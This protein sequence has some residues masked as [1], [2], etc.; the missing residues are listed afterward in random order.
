[1]DEGRPWTVAAGAHG[2][3]AARLGLLCPLKLA[4]R[5]LARASNG[6]GRFSATVRQSTHEA[7][8]LVRGRG[9]EHAGVVAAEPGGSVEFIE[10]AFNWLCL[11]EQSDVDAVTH[12]QVAGI[13]WV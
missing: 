9:A 10:C 1:M 4:I 11:V 13:I 2:L 7:A 3:A 5:K 6:P 12:M 8:G